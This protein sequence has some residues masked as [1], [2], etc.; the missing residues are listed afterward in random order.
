MKSMKRAAIMY[1]LP[2][3]IGTLLFYII[4]FIG[5]LYYAVHS[6]TFPPQFVGGANFLDLI[7]NVMF[8]SALRNTLKISLLCAP[9]AVLLA[10]LLSCYLSRKVRGGSWIRAILLFPYILPTAAVVAIWK[11]FFGYNSSISSIISSI[12]G[13]HIDLIQGSMQIIPTIILYVWRNTGFFTVILVAAMQVIPEELYEY[14]DVEGATILQK[15]IKITIPLIMPSILIVLL[16]A[17]TGS[18]KV[19]KEVY[20]LSGGYPSTDMYTLQHFINNHLSKLNYSVVTSSAYTFTLIL[21]VIFAILFWFENR[22]Q[23]SIGR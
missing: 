16:F 13:Y 5:G 19:F 17:W 9:L 10:L 12:L 11:V 15:H 21:L 4:P 6:D 2:G 3:L 23:E 7:G 20:A 18:L 1:M 14:T 8:R 22:S